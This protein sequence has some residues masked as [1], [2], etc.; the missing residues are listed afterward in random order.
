MSRGLVRR[1]MSSTIAIV[2]AGAAVWCGPGLG[3]ADAAT[4]TTPC[5]KTVRVVKKMQVGSSYGDWFRDV[6]VSSSGSRD[7]RMAYTSNTARNLAVQV[8]QQ[9]L[10]SCYG[11]GLRV[12]G[13]FGSLTR[14][15][16]LLVQRRLNLVED[17][18]Y[19]NVM[20][21]TIRVEWRNT[22]LRKADSYIL[23][24]WRDNGT[25]YRP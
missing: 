21:S 2:V 7:C 23:C 9:D 16:V 8:L 22:P 24:T 14:Q 1:L 17:G 15:A 19:G 25:V 18:W 13:H 6:P 3:V 12:D 10:N 4:S 20:R 5:T 11:T